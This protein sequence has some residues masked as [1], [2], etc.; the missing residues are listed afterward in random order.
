MSTMRSGFSI[1][2]T[3]SM[4]MSVYKQNWLRFSLIALVFMVVLG[5]IFAFSIGGMIGA[6]LTPPTTP[7]PDQMFAFFNALAVPILIILILSLISFSFI[8]VLFTQMTFSQMAGRKQPLGEAM[9][10]AL[11]RLFPVILFYILLFLLLIVGYFVFALT[12]GL[13]LGATL[14]VVGGVLTVILFYV[15]AFYLNALFI[16]AV[17]ALVVERIGVFRAFGR[18]IALSQGHRWAIVGLLLILIVATLIVALVLQ[19]FALIPIIG[20]VALVAL[21]AFYVAYIV[22]YAIGPAVIYYLLRNE[23]EGFGV[24]EVAHVFD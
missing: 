10:M 1:G 22:V 9:S 5:L 12:V 21:F 20:L 18:G 15:L 4:T 23:K 16:S 3:I 24:E 19:L 7:D 11:Q 6:G 17:P 8:Q 14:G 2:N 13:L